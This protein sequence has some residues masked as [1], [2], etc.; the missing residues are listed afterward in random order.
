MST[1]VT[2]V[3]RFREQDSE[4]EESPPSKSD[5]SWNFGDGDQVRHRKRSRRATNDAELATSHHRQADYPQEALQNLPLA[6]HHTV[7]SHPHGGGGESV[8]VHLFVLFKKLRGIEPKQ[9][10]ADLSFIISLRWCAPD[11]T[12][13]RIKSTKDLWTPTIAVLNADRMQYRVEDPW[14]YPLTGDVRQIIHCEGTVAN[15]SDL[16]YFPFDYESVSIVIAAEIGT[17]DRYVRLRWQNDTTNPARQN[18]PR[19]AS[20]VTP[21]YVGDLHMEWKLIHGGNKIKR[22][23]KRQNVN[24]NFSAVEIQLSLTR[25]FGFYLWK[26]MLLVWMIAIMSWS[27]FLIRDIA[28]RLDDTEIFVMRLEFTAALLLAAVSFLYISQ[29]S[30]PRLSYLTSLDT[31]ILFSFFNLFMVVIETVLVRVLSQ[32]SA[33]GSFFFKDPKDVVESIDIKE[34]HTKLFYYDTRIIVNTDYNA[35]L[36]YPLVFHVVELAIPIW[37]LMKRRWWLKE[38][39]SSGGFDGEVDQGLCFE[40]WEEEWNWMNNEG[41][42]KVFRQ[43]MKQMKNFGQAAERRP[44]LSGAQINIVNFLKGGIKGNDLFTKSPKNNDKNYD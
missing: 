24:G 18:L 39:L 22:E 28:G 1:R 30:I 9:S 2:P 3:Q 43:S 38:L 36:F 25:K 6:D 14:F 13:Q 17:G 33:E 34:N 31:M 44:S 37:A 23:P 20:S 4:D 35:M 16:Q 7:S 21:P 5:A 8:N 32:R 15:K 11:L 12:L 42:E 10:C 41:K 40:T 26:I 19:T 29:E 27:T